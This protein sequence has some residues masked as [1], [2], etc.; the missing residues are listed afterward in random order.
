M[1]N[2]Q[3]AKWIYDDLSFQ[4]GE[5]EEKE[6]LQHIVQALDDKDA[7]LQAAE[8]EAKKLKD[9]LLKVTNALSRLYSEVL[10]NDFNEHW[11]SYSDTTTLLAE[12]KEKE[13]KPT[14]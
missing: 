3:K 5:W 14:Q 1:T 4:L 8:E 9:E 11:E 2:E 7:K 13:T 6:L 12:L 10:A